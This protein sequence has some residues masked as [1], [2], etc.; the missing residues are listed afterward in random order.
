MYEVPAN[1]LAQVRR[2]VPVLYGVWVTCP[3]EFIWPCEGDE[4]VSKFVQ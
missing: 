2:T 4:T 3:T 1:N